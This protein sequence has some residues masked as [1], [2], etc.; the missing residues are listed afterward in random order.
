MI[1]P[2]KTFLFSYLKKELAK[3][4]FGIGLDAASA[5]FKNRWMFKT[6]K[7]FGLDKD[8]DSLKDGIKKYDNDSTYGIFADLT[9]LDNLPGNSVDV[10][11]S[12]NTLNHLNKEEMLCAIKH[13]C[14]LA[15][16]GGYFFCELE[17]G[18]DF[19]AAL[20]ILESN[21]KKIKIIYYKNILSNLY[22][23]FFEKDGYL[24][25]HRIAGSRPF[26]A[27]SWL[28]S[29][30]EYLTC[31]FAGLNKYVFII[32][33]GKRGDKKNNFDLSKV[34]II[35]KKIYSLLPVNKL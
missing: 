20:G 33:C 21:F 15:A 16:P 1:R 17:K 9:R 35:D 11:V 10:V 6:E 26:L 14:R 32:C 27:I 12:T 4:N 2:S 23:N 30:F 25:E 29:R 28:I 13:L 34:K 3:I 5:G 24:G 31:Y 22:E 8:F 7:Y 18:G 19:A